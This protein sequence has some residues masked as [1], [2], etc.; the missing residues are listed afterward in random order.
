MDSERKKLLIAIYLLIFILVFIV[1]F[2]YFGFKYPTNLPDLSLNYLVYTRFFVW[3]AGPYSGFINYTDSIVGFLIDFPVALFNALF[4]LRAGIFLNSFIFNAI[5]MLGCFNLIYYLTPNAKIHARIIG[6]LIPTILFLFDFIYSDLMELAFLPWAILFIFLSFSHR[7]SNKKFALYTSL[8]ILALSFDI[9]FSFPLLIA[10]TLIVILFIMIITALIDRK[11]NYKKFLIFIPIILFLSLFINLPLLYSTYML[12]QSPLYIQNAAAVNINYIIHNTIKYNVILIL[13]SF[14]PNNDFTNIDF[15]YILGLITI[16][17]V[18]LSF[19]ST[20]ISSRKQNVVLAHGKLQFVIF[21]SFIVLLFLST[22]YFLPL[23]GVLK[24]LLPLLYTAALPWLNYQLI[25]AFVVILLALIITNAFVYLKDKLKLQ[26]SLLAV[27]AIIICV[28]VYMLW[29]VPSIYGVPVGAANI[30]GPHSV[31]IP[32]HV[33]QISSFINKQT[34]N[35]AVLTLPQMA[36]GVYNGWQ[37][38][39]WYQGVN[40]YSS[41]INHPVYCGFLCYNP[42]SEEFFPSSDIELYFA[43]KSFEDEMTINKSIA[44]ALGVAGIEY[45]IIQGNTLHNLTNGYEKYFSPPEFNLSIIYKNLNETQNIRFIKRYSNS[46]VYKNLDY[47]PLVYGANL[48]NIGN[49]TTTEIF[50]KIENLSFNIY[51]TAIFS[52]DINAPYTNQLYNDSNTINATP[53][54]NFSQ[55]NI[56]FVQNT[57]TKVTVHISNATTPYYLVFRETYDP[58]WAAFYSNGTQVNPRDH[59]AVNGFANAW[60]MN[61][62]GNYTIT[63]YYTLQTDAWLAWGVS[64]AAFFVTIGIGVYGWRGM[65]KEKKN[66]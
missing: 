65:K 43:T 52:T 5:L 42:Y 33:F 35:F 59:I 29:V 61:K 16:V 2:Q 50:N 12:T 32:K 10:P 11:Y 25:F 62:T 14:I 48:V 41:L 27:L 24:S 23:G 39:N 49:A 13:I 1:N 40:V 60:Y 46:T 66:A 53:I 63:L 64:F 20:A 57:P 54:S 8:A 9:R 31:N 44:N 58:H 6:G 47:A 36:R 18:L 38:D 4:G 17:I 3:T 45:I 22:V 19:L 21:L 30:I 55:P 34:G 7:D 26:I 37:F 15:I 28:F 51:N 56:S